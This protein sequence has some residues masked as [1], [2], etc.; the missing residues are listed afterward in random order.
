MYRVISRL[1]PIAVTR[2]GG[3]RFELQKYR[4]VL[5]REERVSWRPA[6]PLSH[7]RSWQTVT[8]C[9]EV[10]DGHRRRRWPADVPRRQGACRRRCPC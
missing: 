10:D 5:R 9:E 4:Q 6:V 1:Q 7:Q 8:G 2:S 3:R